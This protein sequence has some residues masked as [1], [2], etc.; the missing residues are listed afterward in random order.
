MTPHL[1]ALLT[2]QREANPLLSEGEEG[3]RHS[4]TFTGRV[5]DANR[6]PPTCPSA[7]KGLGV[8]LIFGNLLVPPGSLG[9]RRSVL[10]RMVVLQTGSQLFPS[11]P[12][13]CHSW[14]PVLLCQYGR[15]PTAAMCI[16]GV[17]LQL[18]FLY[19]YK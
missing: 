10:L 9:P 11:T 17:I 18:C 12:R 16:T 19:V 13:V 7:W 1:F 4:V 5:G 14:S 3:H 15:H 2:G 6:R 8:T